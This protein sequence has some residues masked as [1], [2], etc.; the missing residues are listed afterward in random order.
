MGTF[1]SMLTRQDHMVI[2]PG[3][4]SSQESQT[5]NGPIWEVCISSIMALLLSGGGQ[6]LFSTQIVDK[7]LVIIAQELLHYPF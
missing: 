6:Q 3:S 2:L 1:S 7:I 4:L 5:D